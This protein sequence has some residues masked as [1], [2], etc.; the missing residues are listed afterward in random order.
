MALPD[1]F[2][3]KSK[4]DWL[5][6]AKSSDAAERK[7][8]SNCLRGLGYDPPLFLGWSAEERVEKILE[9]QDE[10]SGGGSSKKK[11]GANKAKTDSPSKKS[12]STKKSSSGGDSGGGASVD[13]SEALEAIDEL[14]TKVA[15]LEEGQDIMMEYVRE[16]HTMMRVFFQSDDQAKNN[17]EE[18]GNYFH[19]KLLG[20]EEEEDGDED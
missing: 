13:L 20:L 6:L 2:E 8:V 3:E 11:K 4:D 14:K 9:H 10:G 17:L 1:G 18:L 7:Q 15:T 12:S 19:G 5:E 16:T